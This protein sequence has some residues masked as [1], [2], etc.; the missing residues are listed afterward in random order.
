MSSI[1]CFFLE[2]TG[3]VSIHLRRYRSPKPDDTNKCTLQG[4]EGYHN[5]KVY[6]KD[7]AIERDEKGYICNGMKPVLSHD[8]LLWPTQCPCGYVFQ[9]DDEWQRFT[10]QIYRRTDTNEEVTLQNV[11]VGAMWYADWLD[12]MYVS[13]DEH[14]L[15]VKTPGGDWV[16][17]SQANNCTMPDDGRQEKHHCWIRHG[18]PPNITVDKNGVTC[19][20]GAGSIQCGTYHGFLQNGCLEG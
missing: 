4:Y 15:M 17:D 3:K 18:V 8:N 9:E 14:V 16:I 13:Q 7:E 11:P 2:A 6:L 12:R 10:Q 5:A 20:V 19:G 1:R